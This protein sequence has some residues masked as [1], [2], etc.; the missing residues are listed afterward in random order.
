[1]RWSLATVAL[2]P[3]GATA[4]AN[5]QERRRIFDWAAS[6]GF[7]GIEV[8]P[9][10]LDIAH[11][12]DA[13]LLE[14][15]DEAAAS[16][17]AISGLNIN[18][19]L[20]RGTASLG[21]RPRV[22]RGSPDPALQS[23][24]E[25]AIDVA[26]ILSASLVTLS[27]SLPLDGCTRQLLR[28]CDLPHAERDENAAFIRTLAARARPHGIQL[29]LELHDDGLL[30]TPEL[31]LDMLERVAAENVGL[32]PDLGNL[33]R[34]YPNSD[35]RT[36]LKSLASRTNNWHVKN[37]RGSQPSPI[38]DGQIDYAEAMQIMRAAGYTGWVS[39]ESYFGDVF[40]LQAKSLAWLKRLVSHDAPTPQKQGS[41]A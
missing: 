6:T 7:Q 10:W 18:R 33:V 17:L 21:Q 37:Y 12:S 22:V 3:R 40:D 26:A 14:V 29:S 5:Q 24:L 31:C 28:G 2:L 34:S 20:R 30:D 25:R 15:R 41:P 11:F 13:E 39:I 36:A 32:N 27:F 38:W 4:H 19:I 35:W 23:L 9:Q 16:G 1:M 8:S